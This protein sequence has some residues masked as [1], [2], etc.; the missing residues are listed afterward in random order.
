MELLLLNLLIVVPA[1]ASFM[2]RHSAPSHKWAATGG[3]VVSPLSM[4]LYATF[5]AS[6]L[7]LVT[8][9]VGL[10]SLMFHG[11]VGYNMAVY[12]GFIPS[13]TVVSGLEQ[14]LSMEAINAIV[15]GAGYRLLGW[16]IDS[17]LSGRRAKRSSNN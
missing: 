7:G 12:L 17:W 6:P 13:R 11:A 9:L 15:W 4:G 5:F 10:V 16:G 3:L 2:S 1:T 14:H 8:G